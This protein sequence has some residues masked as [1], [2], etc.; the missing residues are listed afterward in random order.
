MCAPSRCHAVE[1]RV[2]VVDV[3]VVVVVIVV[4]AGLNVNGNSAC[5][6][7]VHPLQELYSDILLTLPEAVMPNLV[8]PLMLSDFLTD[9]FKVGESVLPLSLAEWSSPAEQPWQHR[10]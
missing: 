2:V 10:R 8:N 9:S 4:V 3:A 6:V 5:A 7:V 1:L